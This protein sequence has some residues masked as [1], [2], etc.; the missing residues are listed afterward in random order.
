LNAGARPSATARIASMS[1]LGDGVLGNQPVI[2]RRAIR[3]GGAS[4]SSASIRV[5]WTTLR[6]WRYVRFAVRFRGVDSKHQHVRFQRLDERHGHGQMRRIGDDLEAGLHL[7]DAPRPSRPIAER[8]A[9]STRSCLVGGCQAV[10][11]TSVGGTP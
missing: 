2:P 7:E 3:C 10:S 5:I 9:S 6:S 11:S 1:W 4:K 8:C